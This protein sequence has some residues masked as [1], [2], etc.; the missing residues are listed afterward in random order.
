MPIDGQSMRPRTTPQAHTQTN[1]E[2]K[3][4]NASDSDP[5]NYGRWRM[6]RRCGGRSVTGAPETAGIAPNAGLM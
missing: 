4:G 6:S 1:Y 2:S 3:I 5:D